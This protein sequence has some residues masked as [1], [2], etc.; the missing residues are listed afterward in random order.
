[1]Q[2]LDRGEAS[3]GD[4]LPRAGSGFAPPPTWR[5]SGWEEPRWYAERKPLF[6]AMREVLGA[7]PQAGPSRR[8]PAAD[9]RAA[10]QK[11]Q[12]PVIVNAP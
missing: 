4:L 11:V 10:A 1:V 5:W 7:I 6:D 2:S 8:S 9:E 3:R 12:R